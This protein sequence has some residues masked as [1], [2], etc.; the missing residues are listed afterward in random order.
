LAIKVATWNIRGVR[1]E[2][3]KQCIK[4]LIQ[5]NNLQFIGLVETK[6]E[7]ITHWDI[8]KCWGQQNVEW[9]DVQATGNS[10]GLI[11]TWDK[12]S[13]SMVSKYTMPNWI[14]IL[15]KFVHEDFECAVC[16]VYGP[17]DQNQR[18]EMWNQLRILKPNIHPPLLLMGDF[19]EVLH[20][21]ERRH[22]TTQ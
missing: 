22:A 7:R 12:D 3:K 21:S 11:A 20:P 2:P 17:N 10:G 16:V 8:R 19:N 4:H 13:F 18:L 5:E 9:V 15:G 14:C 1:S 6:H